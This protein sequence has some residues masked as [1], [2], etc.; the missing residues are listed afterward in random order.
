[1]FFN[2]I[3]QYTF[4][5][6]A[7]RERVLRHY[8]STKTTELEKCIYRSSSQSFTSSTNLDTGEGLLLVSD[9]LPTPYLQDPLQRIEFLHKWRYPQTCCGY[10]VRVLLCCFLS[11]WLP[12]SSR[13]PI[14]YTTD[15]TL[16]PSP[17]CLCAQRCHIS[18]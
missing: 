5:Q 1:M 3:Q 17:R 15:C 12:D 2:T 13:N 14:P 10:F 7:E 11:Q 8:S 16:G 6:N 18:L 4:T 9:L